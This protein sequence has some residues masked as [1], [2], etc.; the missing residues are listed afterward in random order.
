MECPTCG[1]AS[2]PG[3][4][5]CDCGYDFISAQPSDTP[6]WPINTT[7]SQRLAA[8]WSIFWPAIP[9]LILMAYLVPINDRIA[10]SLGITLAFLTIQALLTHRLVRKKY[11]SFRIYVVRDDG[12][13][14]R[15]LLM[16]GAG[17]VS[18]WILSPQVAVYLIVSVLGWLLSSKLPPETIRSISSLSLW[19]RIFWAGPYG[20]D[21][22]LRAK[23][24]GFRLQAYG[25]RY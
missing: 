13:K 15:K 23:Y 18:L 21:L 14:G 10:F 6:G 24:P 11:R 19:L 9:A 22:A 1:L 25:Q 3:S 7:W 5:T 17:L 20:I 4:F 2:P 16:R 8:S 12:Q